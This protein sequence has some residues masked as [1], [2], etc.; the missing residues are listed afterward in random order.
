MLCNYLPPHNPS[1]SQGPFLRC[2][3]SPA[4]KPA[5][6]RGSLGWWMGGSSLVQML[7]LCS[8]TDSYDHKSTL[9]HTLYCMD[10]NICIFVFLWTFY[11]ILQLAR[12]FGLDLQNIPPHKWYNIWI[13]FPSKFKEIQKTATQFFMGNSNNPSSNSVMYVICKFKNS[14]SYFTVDFFLLFYC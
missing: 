9:N 14:I 11:T 8:D 2:S 3:G 5:G 1:R 7:H 13:F 10:G 6:S 12:F 4:P